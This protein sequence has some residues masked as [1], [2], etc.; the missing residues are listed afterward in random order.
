MNS[1]EAASTPEQIKKG[2]QDLYVEAIG[3]RFSSRSRSGFG[4]DQ[5]FR[6]VKLYGHDAGVDFIETHLNAIVQEAREVATC[7]EASLSLPTYGYGRSAISSMVTRLIELTALEAGTN[8]STVVLT[9]AKA[10]P[11]LIE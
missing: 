4:I 9:W 1:R 10:N 6:D 3:N 11:G 2:I 7:K 8:A 5:L